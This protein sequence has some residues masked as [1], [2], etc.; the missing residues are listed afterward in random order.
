[1]R[2]D[3]SGIETNVG[4]HLSRT[5]GAKPR[6]RRRASTRSRALVEMRAF[7]ASVRGAVA[8]AQQ[9]PEYHGLPSAVIDSPP[10]IGAILPAR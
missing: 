10:E 3:A 4:P 9:L 5:L 6:T 7:D 8:S 2:L 1:M